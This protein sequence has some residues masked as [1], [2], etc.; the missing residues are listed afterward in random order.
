[1]SSG[2]RDGAGP[3]PGGRGQCGG[4]ERGGVFYQR[5]L[6]VRRVGHGT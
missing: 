1:M 2:P 5:A 3:D 6:H 4:G